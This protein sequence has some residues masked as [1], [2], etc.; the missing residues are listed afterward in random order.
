MIKI[1]KLI[2]YKMMVQ[3]FYKL[4]LTNV[5]IPQAAKCF[6]DPILYTANAHFITLQ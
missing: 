2:Y 1:F 5:S 3:N 4:G 6:N